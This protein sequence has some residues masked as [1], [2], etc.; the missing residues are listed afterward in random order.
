MRSEWC[1]PGWWHHSHLHNYYYHYHRIFTII[2]IWLPLLSFR[3]VHVV[4]NP[5]LFPTVDLSLEAIT[6]RIL[7]SWWSNFKDDY[8]PTRHAIPSIHYHQRPQCVLASRILSCFA[9]PYGRY[10]CV[11]RTTILVQCWRFLDHLAPCT[12]RE[13]ARVPTSPCEQREHE[14]PNNKERSKGENLVA[15][16]CWSEVAR[17]YFVWC[18]TFCYYKIQ[19]VYQQIIRPS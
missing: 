2:I 17:E 19:L 10:T 7:S 15:F 14:Q 11:P 4:T 16:S 8:L 6:V 5:Y 9:D 12:G 1:G 3:D 13:R 18:H